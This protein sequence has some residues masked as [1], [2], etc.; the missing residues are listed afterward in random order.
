M[1][2]IILGTVQMGLNYGI[3]NT[4]GKI[5]D[6]AC[7]EILNHA[8]DSGI[9]TLD[10]AEVYGD[11]HELIGQFHTQ[12]PQKK[13]KIITKL[14]SELAGLDI[15]DKVGGYL[16]QMH[17][18]YIDV[19]MF[20]NF[21]SFFRNSKHLDSLI[22]L[23]SSGVINNIGVSVYTNE[24]LEFLLDKALI[25]V[26]QFP[27]NLLDNNFFRGKI[28]DSLKERG[29]VV[30]TRSVFLQGLFF[31]K[32]TNQS[33]IVKKVYNELLAL[34]HL[35]EILN[36]TMEELALSYCLS[37]KNID[38]VVLGIDSLSQLKSNLSAST[39][40][41]NDDVHHKIEQLRVSDKNLLNPSLW[42]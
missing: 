8:H 5:P 14:S 7:F 24:Q 31:K 33:E 39:Y 40:C 23:K 38:N 41:I 25:D 6:T 30:H 9:N 4:V 10:T 17:V 27:F 37:Q 32:L 29:K 11:A 15:E 42:N 12:F 18:E 20:H 13:F 22:D 2:K 19:L 1:S 16:N 28:I 35:L 26:V 34:H 36:C 3:N 21:D